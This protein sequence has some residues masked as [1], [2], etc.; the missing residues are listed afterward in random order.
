MQIRWLTIFL[1]FPDQVYET[2][3]AYWR[4]VTDSGLS[5]FRGAAE[6]EFATLLPADGDAY[7][8]VQ[9]VRE[10]NGGCHLDLHIDGSAGS[11]DEAAARAVTLGALMRHR[12]DDLVILDSPGGFPFCLVPWDGEKSVPGPVTLDHGGASRL[13]QLCLDI[14]PGSYERECSFWAALSGWELRQGSLPEFAYLE[15]PAGMP[16]RL[17]LQRRQIASARDR[18]SAH[19]D[20]SCDDPSRLAQ[21]HIVT[22]GKILGTFPHWL[23]MA[24]PS[25]REYCLTRRDPRSGKLPVTPNA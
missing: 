16:A 23:M 19:V 24:D 12:E 4:E 7:L 9:R 8:R 22:G 15:R 14:P 1:D 25:G 10:G 21:R 5:A 2:G 20:F 17:L 11:I 13:D 6:S 18:V 3:V